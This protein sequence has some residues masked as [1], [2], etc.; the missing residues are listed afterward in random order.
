[1]RYSTYGLHTGSVQGLVPIDLGYINTRTSIKGGGDFRVNTSL[2][3]CITV[4][5]RG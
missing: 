5:L 2:T 4:R 1:M 3:P